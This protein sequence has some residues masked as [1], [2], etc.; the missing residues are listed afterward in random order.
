MAHLTPAEFTQTVE[1]LAAHFGVE[2]LRERLAR[3]NAFTSRRGLNTPAA[4]A[5]RL[6]VL[7]GGLRRQVP[8]TYAFST[9]WNEMVHARLGEDAE[10]RLET[11]VEEVNGCLEKDESIVPGKEGALDSA[12]AAYRDV[13]AA[14]TGRPEVA[15]LDMLLKAV[16]SVADRLRQAP[17]TAAPAEPPAGG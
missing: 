6:H 1:A 4:I 7:S 16:P 12:L 10:K 5:E 17:P 3:M 11:I 13:L 15:R 2:Q 14:A 8:A 9:I